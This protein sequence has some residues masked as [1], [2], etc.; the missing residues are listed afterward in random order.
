MT[1]YSAHVTFSKE[2]AS[3]VIFRCTVPLQVKSGINRQLMI[4]SCSGGHFFNLK[5]LR[6]LKSVNVFSALKG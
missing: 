3:N 5:G 1:T 6:P 4:S 2:I